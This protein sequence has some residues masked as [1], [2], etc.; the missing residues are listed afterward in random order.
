MKD[1]VRNDEEIPL[2]PD[3]H[4]NEKTFFEKTLS[5]DPKKRFQTF[6]EL[7]SCK[8]LGSNVS[9]TSAI[10][11][12]SLKDMPWM[13]FPLSL[14]IPKIRHEK[15]P[16]LK[17]ATI[18]FPK[19]LL[20]TEMAKNTTM[21]HAVNEIGEFLLKYLDG[22]SFKRSITKIDFLENNSFADNIVRVILPSMSKKCKPTVPL[23]N[24][25][26]AKYRMLGDDSKLFLNTKNI[27]EIW[28]AA[29]QRVFDKWMKEVVL[30]SPNYSKLQFHFPGASC[31]PVVRGMDYEEAVECAAQGFPNISGSDDGY[32]GKAKYFT[33]SLEYAGFY[34]PSTLIIGFLCAGDFYKKLYVISLS[35]QKKYYRSSISSC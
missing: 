22:H 35:L 34:D 8:F 13:T 27:P 24:D 15:Y 19:P 9:T 10:F 20:V 4:G 16:T 6:E 17:M 23:W 21:N 2:P 7:L 31:I 11:S 1:F 32:Y 3:F 26:N 33:T 25:P 12:D 14:S 28:I 30:K 18:S 5:K 29:R